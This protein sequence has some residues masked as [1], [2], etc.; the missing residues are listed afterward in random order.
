[1]LVLAAVS[2][3]Q[4][5]RLRGA[6]MPRFTLARA[7]TWDVALETIKCRPVEI[8]VVDPMLGGAQGQEVERL[9]ILFPSL[10]FI[11]YTPVMTPELAPVLLHMGKCGITQVVLSRTE[12]H[13]TRLRDLLSAEAMHAA[14]H[15][16]LEQLMT[17]LA[18]TLQQHARKY[19]GLT[20][21]EMKLSLTADQAT[22]R[23]VQGFLTPAT[24]A[25]A[26]AS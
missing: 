19:L 22:A 6:V 20:A 2:D 15:Q 13:P 26:T 23:I 3:V 5:Q 1:M 17:A 11:L 12:D 18:K 7:A 4:Y 14:S 21:G 25:A 9:R 24:R 16:L 8:A 10:P